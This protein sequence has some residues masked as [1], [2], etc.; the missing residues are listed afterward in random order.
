MYIKQV[1]GSCGLSQRP[2]DVPRAKPEFPREN[3]NHHFMTGVSTSARINNFERC[4]IINEPN[5]NIPTEMNYAE[6][7]FPFVSLCVYFLTLH[8]VNGK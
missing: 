5:N 3:A 6:T 7:T 8:N 4:N 1:R 2:N